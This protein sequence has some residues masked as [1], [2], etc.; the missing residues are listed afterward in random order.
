MVR[1][2]LLPFSYSG[3][4]MSTIHEPGLGPS[5][6]HMISYNAHPNHRLWL[7]LISTSPREELRLGETS[8]LPEISQL[9]CCRVCFKPNSIWLPPPCIP[10]PWTQGRESPAFPAPHPF[11]WQ[12]NFSLV[13][14]GINTLT[15]LSIELWWA[16]LVLIRFPERFYFVHRQDGIPDLQCCPSDLGQNWPHQGTAPL[17]HLCLLLW[18]SFKCQQMRAQRP[19]FYTWLCRTLAL[20][21][22]SSLTTLG[23][24][25]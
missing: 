23:S 25:F 8:A 4:W 13:L 1:H 24:L 20:W 14:L 6:L 9:A 3:H 10:W 15:S 11:S 7:L 16:W 22:A 19:A 2:P 21:S 5:A 17:S 18:A 12:Q